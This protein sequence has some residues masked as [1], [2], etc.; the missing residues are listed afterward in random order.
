AGAV[1]STTACSRSTAPASDIPGPWC[2]T[3]VRR[4]E[5]RSGRGLHAVEILRTLRHPEGVRL[6]LGIEAQVSDRKRS[7]LHAFTKPMLDGGHD[8]PLPVLHPFGGDHDLGARI[9]RR[10]GMTLHHDTFLRSPRSCEPRA[11]D[12]LD[13]VTKP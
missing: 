10:V 7:G 4:S 5:R 6:F 3:A 1:S 12:P 2:E 9:L 11:S 8:A 13:D